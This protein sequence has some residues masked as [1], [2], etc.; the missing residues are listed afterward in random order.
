MVTVSSVGLARY[1]LTVLS[2]D[3]AHHKPKSFAMLDAAND[4]ILKSAMSE[5]V[6]D[7]EVLTWNT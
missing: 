5:K 7:E 6:A 4:A 3:L 2:V 1:K